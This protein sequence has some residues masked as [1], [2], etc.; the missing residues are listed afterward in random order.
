LIV[1]LACVTGAYLCSPAVASVRRD[2]VATRAY[3]RASDAYARDAYAQ[4]RASVA[5]IEASASEIA[6]AC[7]GALTYAPRDA[8]FTELGEE[9]EGTLLFAG[10]K[11]LRSIILRLAQAIG[12]LSW[13]DH[14]LTR[15]V[16]ARAAEEREIAALATPDMCAEIEAWKA[17]AYAALP[18]SAS[19]FVARFSAIASS[20]SVG[21]SE[22]QR[23]TVILRRL[24]HHEGRAERATAKRIEALEARLGKRL[25]AAVTSGQ[26]K[27]TAALG[28]SE[29]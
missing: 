20:S 15:L 26:K 18:Q 8:A 1:T 9:A 3:L 19:A 12:H 23:E 29:L 27:L 14:A 24:R 4:V 22:E 25:N 7:P 28:V 11:P 6:A 16:R 13:S 21:P 2:S 5:A 17:S 10:A